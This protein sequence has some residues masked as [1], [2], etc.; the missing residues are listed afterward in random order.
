M[1]MVVSFMEW[2]VDS[3]IAKA[4]NGPEWAFPVVQSFHFI[5]FALL[6][7]TIAIVD[8]RL[9]GFG[10]TRQTAAQL[11]S[12]FAPWTRAGLVVMLTTG[13]CMFSADAVRYHFN[14]SFQIKMMCLLAAIVFHFTIVRKVTRS[15]VS[16]VLGKL[17]AIVSLAL[18][19]SVVAAGR[20]IAFV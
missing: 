14:P 5:G 11:A 1:T 15:D 20:M 3:P 10:M 19:I 16:P 9:L 17:V 6:I 13:F 2:L 8:L 18:W 12:D 4:M 7:G